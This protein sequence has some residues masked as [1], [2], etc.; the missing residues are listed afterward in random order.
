MANA[1]DDPTRNDNPHK[2]CE[3]MTNSSKNATSFL[4]VPKSGCFKPC[5]LQFLRRRRSLALLCTLLGSVALIFVFLRPTAFRTT[6]FANFR[7]VTHSTEILPNL[8]FQC[9]SWPSSTVFLLSNSTFAYLSTHFA[10]LSVG[11]ARL[12]ALVLQRGAKRRR[13]KLSRNS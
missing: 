3:K 9:W 5:C 8:N 6:A 13:L 2:P 11:F 4:G 12:A 10:R 1:R 7:S